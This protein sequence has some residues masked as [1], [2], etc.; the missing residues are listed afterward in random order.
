MSKFNTVNKP[1]RNNDPIQTTSLTSNTTTHQGGPGFGRDAKSELF[2]LAVTNMVGETT[3]Y[4]TA[5]SRDAR[6]EALC[7]EVAVT[8]GEWF[9]DFIRWL[10][11]RANMRSASLVAACAGVRAR[12]LVKLG[13]NRRFISAILAR[14]DEP[15]ELIAYWRSRFGQKVPSAVQ[16]GINDAI[17]GMSN[18]ESV[19]Q[20]PLYSEYSLLK[21]DTDSHGYRFAD[22]IALTHVK[23][24]TTE[25]SNLFSY[26]MARRYDREWAPLSSRADVL[27]M[28]KANRHLRQLSIKDP[29]VL[30]STQL[31]HRAGMTWEDVL[32]LA[33]NRLDKRALWEALIPT[34]GFMALLRNLRNFDEAGVSDE[35]AQQVIAKLTDPRQVARSRQLPLRFLSAYRNAPSVRWSYPLEQALQL[36]L[37]NIPQ[38]IGKT[39]ILVDTSGSMH[40]RLSAKSDLLRWDA[41]TMFGLAM[42]QRCDAATVVS[43][44]NTTKE[45]IARKGES[46]LPQ[47][48]RWQQAGFFMGG[49]TNTIGALAEYQNQAWD[50]IVILTD[51]QVGQF[52]GYWGRPHES[53]DTI[54]APTTPLYTWNLA[55]YQAGHTSSKPNRHTFG[56]LSDAAF[57]M[58]PLMEDSKV[59][60]WPWSS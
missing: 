21:Y 26:A 36:S 45:F 8:D 7:A 1:Y 6:F 57:S 39:L 22:V 17:T 42:A 16:R 23:P 46:L 25:Q 47:I 3:F 52:A 37:S 2:L 35:V 20:G 19:G 28:I 58:V 14:A 12:L 54:V 50:R 32:S 60:R 13:D 41:A 51:E 30:L 31:L 48:L 33:G 9:L 34:M 24:V 49:G 27:P 59:G 53:V 10:R 55:G 29:G 4:E 5:D 15:G 18:G 38:L 43:F 56:G 11:Y 44:S 40:S